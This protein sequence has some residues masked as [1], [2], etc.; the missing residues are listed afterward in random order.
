MYQILD[1]LNSLKH[2]MN[3]FS[4]KKVSFV[5]SNTFIKEDIR[6]T[7]VYL[8]ILCVVNLTPWNYKKVSC[9][10]WTIGVFL[11]PSLCQ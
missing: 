8:K 3:G 2:L 4:Y 6:S 5:V 1:D 11:S 10:I 7:V 9:F